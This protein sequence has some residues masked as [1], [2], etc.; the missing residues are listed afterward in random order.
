SA[1]ARCSVET[2]SVA[3]RLAPPRS[4][5]GHRGRA[6]GHPGRL[7]GS[8][9]SFGANMWFAG[10]DPTNMPVVGDFDNDGQS[11]RLRPGGTPLVPRVFSR[12]A[13]RKGRRSATR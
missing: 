5:T 13:R 4:E 10:S 11:L 12:G 8:V 3:G 1:A 7:K 6:P 2:R 9:T